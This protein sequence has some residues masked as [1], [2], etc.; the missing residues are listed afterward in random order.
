M[1]IQVKKLDRTKRELSIE[2]SGDILKNKFDEVYREV[3]KTAKVKGFRDGNVPRDILEQHYSNA[4]KE[5]VLRQLIPDLY[6]QALTQESIDPA[7][8]PEITDV[9]LGADILSFKASV[10]VKPKI[11]LKNYKGL[12]AQH[13]PIEV[14]PD[15]VTSAID[16]IKKENFKEAT[17]DS[18]VKSLG[19]PGIDELKVVL[20]KQTYLEKSRAQRV[21]LENSIIEQLLKQV[22]FDVPQSLIDQ[23]L[24]EL[25]KQVKLDLALRGMPKEEIE[26]QEPA[27]RENLKSRSESD[28]RVYLILEEVARRE[29]I[30]LNENV[31]QKTMEFLL[32]EAKWENA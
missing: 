28:V 31:A 2:V 23:H 30:P 17:D 19:Y 29:N 25:I 21:G 18:W 22:S 26:K 15:E 14:K 16:K 4:A 27:L 3:G 13:K 24:E 9:N 10:E 12:K 11:E 6:G 32:K 8:M 5:E 7:G 20:E 1:K